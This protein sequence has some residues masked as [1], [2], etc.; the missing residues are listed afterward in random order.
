MSVLFEQ[1]AVDCYCCGLLF[2][3]FF[4]KMRSSAASLSLSLSTVY[5]IWLLVAVKL[6]HN[7]NLNSQT[8]NDFDIPIFYKKL[9]GPNRLCY[10]WGIF[11]SKYVNTS[12]L[13]EK[14]TK[15]FGF[16]DM[17]SIR[18][19]KWRLENLLLNVKREPVLCNFSI[20][21]QGFL[22]HALITNCTKFD[23]AY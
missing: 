3:S 6:C 14:W 4:G 16:L 5:Q 17:K 15:L 8:S 11:K 20:F 23:T 22:P 1:C 10:R 12:I 9:N 21:D 7:W 13:P 19:K 2:G 18:E